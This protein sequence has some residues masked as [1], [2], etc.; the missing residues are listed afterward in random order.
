M[1]EQY[2]YYDTT[3]IT[4]GIIITWIV[5]LLLYLFSASR[6]LVKAG[7]PAWA[8]FIPIY[9]EYL[10]IK[11]SGKPGWWLWLYLVPVLNIVIIIW[12]RN[13]LS[14]SFGKGEGFTVGLILLW[15]IFFP[16]LAFDNDIKYLGPFGNKDEFQARQTKFDFENQ[17]NP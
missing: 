10:L 9:N 2:Y 5:F 16:I 4:P 7:E 17:N 6:I 11:I 14:K 12:A 15:I 1:E 8:G 3:V 13:M